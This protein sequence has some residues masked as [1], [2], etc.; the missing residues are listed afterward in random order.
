MITKDRRLYGARIY[1]YKTK[2]IG[3]LICTW[4]NRFADGDVD[5]AT[6]VDPN[7]KKYNAPMDEITPLEMMDIEELE[8]LGIPN[9]P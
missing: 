3:L 2:E 5:F 4:V 8:K 9:Y 6:C 7:G 1:N